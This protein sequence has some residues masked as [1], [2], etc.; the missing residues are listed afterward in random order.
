MEHKTCKFCNKTDHIT[1]KHTCYICGVE[2]QHKARD[3]CKK[4]ESLEHKNKDHPIE[5]GA[6]KICNMVTNHTTEEHK[7]TICNI[8]GKHSARNHCR[9]CNELGHK[10]SDHCKKCEKVGHKSADHICPHPHCKVYGIHQHSCIYCLENHKTS[11]HVCDYYMCEQKGH[12]Y[13]DHREKCW[14][15]LCNV[16]G[17]TKNEPHF[18][19][20]KCFFTIINNKHLWCDKCNNCTFEDRPHEDICEYCG[21]CMARTNKCYECGDTLRCINCRKLKGDPEKYDINSGTKIK[22]SFLTVALRGVNK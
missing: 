11:E 18:D 13:N 16:L 8:K 19:C 9:Q 2:G 1:E 15:E 14:C 6:C 4:C 22:K 7:C 3:H 20:D 5:D 10:S 21:S 12:S 17:H